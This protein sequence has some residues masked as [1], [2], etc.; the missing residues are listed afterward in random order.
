MLED[1]ELEL[2]WIGFELDP[3]TPRGGRDLAELFGSDRL[4][5]MRAQLRNVAASLG[6]RMGEPPRVPNTRRALALVEQCRAAGAVD[7]A[8]NALMDAHWVQGRDIGSDAVLADVARH[9]GLDPVAA[10][11]GC[12]SPAWHARVDAMRE[13]ASR[14]GVTGI[15]TFFLLPEGWT[16]ERLAE[17]S[18]PQPVR[19]V[20]SRSVAELRAAARQ[21][22]A[23][24]G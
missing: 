12:D 21:V 19:V 23:L 5:E 15:P 8:R 9:A 2:D 24:P 13:T 16:E 10:V 7:L 17:W 20:G 6:V 4:A 18:G 14:W 1:L 11:A 3:T 22:G